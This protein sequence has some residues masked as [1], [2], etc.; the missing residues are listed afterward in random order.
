M[1]SSSLATWLP[2]E[3]LVTIW[4]ITLSI[5]RRTRVAGKCRTSPAREASDTVAITS[6][7]ACS[8]SQSLQT[9]EA[10]FAS[11]ALGIAGAFLGGCQP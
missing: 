10:R 3:T 1:H 6:C 2:F 9:P 4:T 7:L 5:P 11:T 8:S